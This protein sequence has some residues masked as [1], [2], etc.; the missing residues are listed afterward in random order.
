MP[1]PL[2]PVNAPVN[3]INQGLFPFHVNSEFFREWIQIT[4]FWNFMGTEMDRPIVRHQMRAGEGWQYSVGKLNALDFTS[5]VLNFDQVSGSGQ[6]QDVDVDSVICQGISFPVTIKGRQLLELGTPIRLPEVVRPQLIEASQ[7]FF[8]KQLLDCAMFNYMSPTDPTTSGYTPATNLPSY[9]R[10]ACAGINNGATGTQNTADRTAYY[11]MAGITTVANGLATGPAYNQNGLSANHLLK[12]KAIATRGGF[13]GGAVFSNGDIEDAVRPAF[14]KSRMGFPMN[15]YIYL[16]TSESIKSL[17]SDPMFFQST[18]ARG[19]VIDS[20]NQP[21]TI[22]GSEYHGKFFGIHIYEIKDLSRYIFT[23]Q[24]TNKQV[25]WEL[26]IGA[27]AWSAGWFEEPTIAFK[28]NQID[29]IQE[30]TTHE[31]RGQKA[32]KFP[33]KQPQAVVAGIY[34]GLVEQGIIHSFVRVA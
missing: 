28:D 31:I 13:V 14:M 16:C 19:T 23:S 21:Q 30:F 8:N 27:G 34:N 9:D 26:F 2:Y 15:D 1:A 29:R 24:D 3:G 7:R 12:L 11:A 20:A 22:Y 10:L 18:A 33:S 25:A 32:L 6:Y 4:P 17:Y 5:P